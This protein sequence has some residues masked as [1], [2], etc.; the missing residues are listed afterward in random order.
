MGGLKKLSIEKSVKIIPFKLLD[1]NVIN[2]HIQQEKYDEIYN[3]V[4]A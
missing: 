4:K 3:L 1:E 2:K